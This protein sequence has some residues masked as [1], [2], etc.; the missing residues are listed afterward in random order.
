MSQTCLNCLKYTLCVF[1]FICWLCGVC[2]MG[3]AIYLMTTSTYASLVPSLSSLNVANVLIIAGTIVTCVSFLGFLGALRENRCLLISFFILL[4]LVMLLQLAMAILLLIYE[5]DIDLFLEKELKQSLNQAKHNATSDWDNVQR[6]LHC[7]GIHNSSDWRNNS[8]LHFPNSC[9]KNDCTSNP[10]D[11]WP[12]GCYTK[13]KDWFEKN[14]LNVGV[15]VIILCIIEVLGMCFSMTLFCH[16]SRSGL[17]F[18]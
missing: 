11:I 16:I 9:C 13:L 10:P 8:R 17:G 15:G 6:L 4:F 18:K 1:N 14:F 2:V 7:C 12:E 5:R 3:F